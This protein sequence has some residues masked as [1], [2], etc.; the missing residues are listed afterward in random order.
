MS[1]RRA[2]NV[3]SNRRSKV[4]DERATVDDANDSPWH[5]VACSDGVRDLHGSAWDRP[6]SRVAGR[7]LVSS[8]TGYLQQRGGH[9][10]SVADKASRL[11]WAISKQ[12]APLA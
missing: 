3:H 12:E 1:A 2:L 6:V 9:G 11:L 8:S 7:E 10:W 4:D 5:D